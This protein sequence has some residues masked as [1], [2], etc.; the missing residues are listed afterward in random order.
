[1]KGWGWGVASN[2]QGQAS[3][4]IWRETIQFARIRE[5]KEVHTGNRSRD[6]NWSK[7]MRQRTGAASNLNRETQKRGQ[8]QH[9]II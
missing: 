3:N 9:A 6:I 7:G 1:M 4:T 2:L 8:E 5:G